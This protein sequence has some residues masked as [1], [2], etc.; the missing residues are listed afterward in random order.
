LLVALSD[1]DLASGELFWDDGDSI[2]NIFTEA[3]IRVQCVVLV[4]KIK[5][6][7]TLLTC[8]F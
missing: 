6:Q 7:L 8:P 3:K 1:R 4:L 5:L 2:G